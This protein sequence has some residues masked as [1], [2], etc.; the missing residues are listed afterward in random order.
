MANDYKFVETNTEDIVTAMVAAYEEL[1]GRTINPASPERLFIGWAA[2]VI[3]QTRELINFA[4]N[5]NIPSRATGENLDAI[6]EIFYTKARPAAT[7]AQCT[8]RF[9]ISAVQAAA[10]VIP[11]GTRITDED[12]TL[13][14]ETT[15]DAQIEA[16]SLY[17]DVTAECQTA[18]EVGNA[19]MSGQINQL[20]DVFAYYDH[21]ENITESDGG[22]E[23]ANDAEF[24][25]M[26]RESENAYP[27]AGSVGAYIYW[28]KTAS[29]EIQDILVIRPVQTM[30][31][32]L[33]VYDHHA[34]IGGSDLVEDSLVVSVNGAV[35]G[36]DTDYTYTYEDGL[37]TIALKDSG[38]Y[39][40]TPRLDISIES[41]LAGEVW[42]YG[43]MTDGTIPGAEMKAKI[44][45]ICSADEVRPLTDKVSVKDPLA[46]SYDI[47]LT[48]YIQRGSDANTSEIAAAVNEAVDE[49]KAWQS[50]KLGRDINPSK[51]IS[52]V[53][54]TGV[55]RVDVRSP[56]YTVL[57]DGSDNKP[58]A[59][60]L[61]GTVNIVNGGF[62]DE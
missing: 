60:A 6:A 34:F 47:D 12:L 54:A 18:G 59:L 24:Y 21:C 44:L 23:E 16:G 38:S 55:K 10:I 51:L 8:M 19:W 46:A 39:Y 36:A 43:L 42:I 15:A 32:N 58:P 41:I 29:T 49:Y 17:A 26:L 5:Q 11:A 7:A 33:A 1:V 27:S 53:M 4:A 28:A 57:A 25:T 40:G 2:D 62:E 52:L 56:T 37:L 45:S 35:L 14:W 50:G 30:A 20:I 22:S 48:Y 13:T 9:T 31:K 3:V 61:A